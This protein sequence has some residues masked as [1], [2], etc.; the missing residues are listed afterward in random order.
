MKPAGLQARSR[1]AI[2]AR[3]LREPTVSEIALHS[4]PNTQ[5]R[6]LAASGA[7]VFLFVNPVEYHGPHLSLDND[8]LI[9]RGLAAD[10]HARLAAVH[11]DWPY[12][13]AG[14]LGMGSGAVPGPGSRRTPYPRLRDQVVDACRSLAT[15]GARRVILMTFHGDP[16]HN[17]ALQA[18]ADWLAGQGIPALVPMHL[19]IRELMGLTADG[20][21]LA[22]LL[23]AV[24]D[25][26]DRQA[27]AGSLQ[28]DIHAGFGETSLTLHYAPE[29]VSPDYRNVPPCPAWRSHPA[30]AL[31]ANAARLAGVR[32]F[33]AEAAYAAMG[34]G[35]LALRP[36]PGYTGRPSLA[37]AEVGAILSGLIVD[38]FAQATLD[39]F[40]RGAPAPRPALAWLETLTVGGR[41]Y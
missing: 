33:A 32:D 27:L 21:R 26:A 29:T 6:A 11:P 19:L 3:S 36:F 1:P 4:L 9:S 35:W 34:L 20:G 12:L 30:V 39:V 28:T 17:L 16:M 31:L 7:P 25:A 38:T 10:I 2:I 41:A 8:A 24:P 23:D 37:R 22:P 18:G 14:E 15:L 40:D 13:T 5:A